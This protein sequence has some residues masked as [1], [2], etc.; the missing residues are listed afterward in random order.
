MV[1]DG[2][3]RYAQIGHAHPHRFEP[4]LDDLDEQLSRQLV[5]DSTSEIRAVGPADS[6]FRINNATDC[7]E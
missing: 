2:S 7:I 6:N 1:N 3:A 5:H 4:N